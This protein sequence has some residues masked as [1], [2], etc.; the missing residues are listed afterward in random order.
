MEAGFMRKKK[1]SWE[2]QQR[3]DQQSWYDE[4]HTTQVK[5]KLN[6]KTDADILEWLHKQQFSRDKSMQGEIK[7]LIREEIRK[8]SS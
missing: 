7:R 8:A 4:M 1:R 3:V 5:L 6:N 2:E